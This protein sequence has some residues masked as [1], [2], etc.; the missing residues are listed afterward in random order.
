M[1]SNKKHKDPNELRL[2]LK[3][4]KSEQ[5]EP[6]IFKEELDDMYQSLK[7]Y[8]EKKKKYK[9]ILKTQQAEIK[10]IK[11]GKKKTKMQEDADLTKSKIKTCDTKSKEEKEK[12]ADQKQRIKDAMIRAKTL[13]PKLNIYTLD[14]ALSRLSDFKDRPFS[15]DVMR[16]LV[17]CYQVVPPTDPLAIHLRD[18]YYKYISL[19][20]KGDPQLDFDSFEELM[21]YFEFDMARIEGFTKI[22]FVKK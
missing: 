13:D 7:R 10:V 2:K 1:A 15:D 5:N 3:N 17:T 14:L 4:A 20:P 11:E 9:D 22:G 18:F 6:Y 21:K 8:A 16:K 19:L 12:I